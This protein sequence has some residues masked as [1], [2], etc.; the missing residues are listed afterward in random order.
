MTER[1]KVPTPIERVVEEIKDIFERHLQ[2][3]TASGDASR[4]A[5][6]DAKVKALLEKLTGEGKTPQR[7]PGAAADD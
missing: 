2:S 3:D 4:E 6:R 5:E 7:T 1:K